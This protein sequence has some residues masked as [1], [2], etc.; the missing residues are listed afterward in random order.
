MACVGTVPTVAD[1]AIDGSELVVRLSV[2]EK[3]GA[4][5]G[6]VRVPL[7]DVMSVRVSDD[8]WSELRG[9]RAPGTGI[10][11]LIAL[12]TRRAPGIRD[13]AAV[14][15]RR[16]KAVVVECSGVDINRIV[17]TR[18]DADEKVRMI[19]EATGAQLHG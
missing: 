4:F 3:L 17:V 2:L 16:R 8:Q 18:S 10:P 13:F 5:R 11:G 14:Y 15:G 1:F 19:V 9:M 7:T 6:N 12:C